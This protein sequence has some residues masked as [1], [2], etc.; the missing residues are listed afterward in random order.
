MHKDSNIQRNAAG[1]YRL[2]GKYL[3]NSRRGILY[4]FKVSMSF[5]YMSCVC[6]CFLQSSRHSCKQTRFSTSYFTKTQKSVHTAS[7]K[8]SR[9]KN[10]Y[11]LLYKIGWQCREVCQYFTKS[12]ITLTRTGNQIIGRSV[13]NSNTKSK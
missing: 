12:C 9:F 7:M 8:P 4:H 13:R 1:E 10:A 2:Y 3:N 5:H 6:P 11:Y